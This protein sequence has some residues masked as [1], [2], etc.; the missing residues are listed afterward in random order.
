MIRIS[1]EL[2]DARLHSVVA[3]LSGGVESARVHVYD[4]ARPALGAVPA[5]QLLATIPFAQ[6]IGTVADG[7]LTL[8]PTV[9]ALI[10]ATGQA[11]WAR[12][13]NGHGALAWDCDVSDLNGDGE[14]RLPST[15]LYAGG[16]TRIV[17]GR[18]G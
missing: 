4:G 1:A 7:G 10:A 12:V 17:S 9:E 6:P 18:L 16:Y 13:V 14:L 2:N 8:A 11:S 5:G 3:F 15:T